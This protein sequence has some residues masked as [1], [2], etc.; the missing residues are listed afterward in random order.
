MSE[1]KR[2]EISSQD[3]DRLIAAHD[4]EVALLYI[5]RLRTGCTDDERTARDLCMTLRAVRETSE[6]LE[7]MTQPAGA[8]Q[9]Y[10]AVQELSDGI[11][12]YTSADVVRRSE[13]DPAFSAIVAEATR[14]MGKTISSPDLKILFGIYEH[15]GMPAEV[16][17]LMLN[18]CAIVY[19]RKYG[20][21]R[22]PSMNAFRKEALYWADREI[23]T[24]EAA[25][26]YIEW[27]NRRTSDIGRIKEVLGI[28]GRELVKS[29]LEKI[30]SWLDMG[31]SEDAISIAYER[32]VT[33]TGAL[34]WNYM[35]KII[36]S[37][38]EKNLLTPQEIEEKDGRRAGAL[39]PSGKPKDG[40]MGKYFSALDDALSKI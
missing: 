18:Y 33:N 8:A 19:E 26:E 31:F 15:L 6:K 9:K 20:S 24:I 14:I 21:Q 10:A 34:K 17:L 7:R 23:L 28:R 25:E 37:W 5:Y 4:A 27:Q 40:D 36:R 13:S 29:E 38:K 11:P 2:F 35:D 1:A 32:T 12:E 39:K 22:R 3:V 30:N 16:V